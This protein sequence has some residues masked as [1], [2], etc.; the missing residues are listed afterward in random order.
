MLG[1][2]THLGRFF[3]TEEN[4]VPGRDAV[5]VLGHGFWQRRFGSDAQLVGRSIQLN[6]KPF[7]VIGITHPSF[8]GLRREMPDMWLPLAMRAGMSTTRFE[9]VAPEKRDWYNGRDFPW[10]SIYGR[11]M[12]SSLCCE[13]L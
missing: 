5:V 3:T 6:G 1:G 11:L 4:S 10:L 8:V 2:S 7:T 9:G 12:P 13:C